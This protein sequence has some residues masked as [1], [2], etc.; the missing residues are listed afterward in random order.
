M[1][2]KQCKINELGSLMPIQVSWLTGTSSRNFDDFSN[3]IT[4]FFL[5]IVIF[6]QMNFT[7]KYCITMNIYY[8]RI[9]N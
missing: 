9:I 7:T 6:S 8:L 1:N 5:E 2:T 4:T 3:V